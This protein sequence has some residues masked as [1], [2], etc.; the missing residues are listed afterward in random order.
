MNTANRSFKSPPP[1][2]T[3]VRSAR[4]FLEWCVGEIGLGYHPDTQG[5]AYD[6]PLGESDARRLDQLHEAAF[7]YLGDDVYRVAFNYYMKKFPRMGKGS[8]S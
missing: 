8:V 4:R 3:N 5:A 6:P 2:V 1:D 7:N